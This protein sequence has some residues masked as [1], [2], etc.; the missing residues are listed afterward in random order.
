MNV[1]DQQLQELAKR[2]ERLLPL[3]PSA[4]GK[5]PIVI[6]FSGSP[7]SGKSTNIDIITHFFRRMGF[8]V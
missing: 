3:R 8:R 1:D 7:K 6:E 4:I 5:P 2:A